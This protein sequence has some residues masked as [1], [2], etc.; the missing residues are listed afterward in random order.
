MKNRVGNGQ[1]DLGLVTWYP[2]LLLVWVLL[3]GR[4][5]AFM[6]FLT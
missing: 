3:R 4:V 1:T 6:I 5:V 2:M